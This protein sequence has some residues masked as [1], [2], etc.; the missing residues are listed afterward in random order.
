LCAELIVDSL[1]RSGLV[2]AA[3]HH[4]PASCRAEQLVT[5]EL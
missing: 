5:L 3:V 1:A 4:S 2:V